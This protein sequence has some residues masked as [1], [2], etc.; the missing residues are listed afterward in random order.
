MRKL[1]LGVIGT[2]K[3]E[4]ERRVPIHP[5][6]LSRIPEEYRRQLIFEEGYGAP[7][8]VSDSELA[9]QTGGVASRRELLAGLGNVI[10]AKPTLADLKD[11]RKRRG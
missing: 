11:L 2:S 8:D 3:K 5:D 6:H 10:M 9:L 1:T 7:F 4:D